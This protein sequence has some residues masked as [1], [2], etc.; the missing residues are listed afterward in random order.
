[1]TA[2]GAKMNQIIGFSRQLID[3][4]GAI[5]VETNDQIDAGTFD[6][7]KWAQAMLK[8]WDFGLAGSVDLASD[9]LA[10]CFTCPPGADEPEYSD[11]LSAPDSGVARKVSVVPGS[12]FHVGA[13]SFVIEDY[14]IS[15][16]PP[17]LKPHVT[18]F[19]VGVLWTGLRSGTYRGTVRLQPEPASD[20]VIDDILEV[21]VDL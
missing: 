16:D 17:V 18:H 2:P 12:F 14:R 9:V 6:Y 5:A 21:I 13:P 10:P 8:L 1:M 3:H 7:A 4:A 19:R 20:V 11:Y 15:I